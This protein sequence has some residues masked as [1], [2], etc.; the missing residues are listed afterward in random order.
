MLVSIV[1]R[2]YNE[3]RYLPALLAAIAA[4]DLQGLRV[5]TILVDSGST[6]G[7]LQIAIRAGCRIVTIQKTEFSFGRSLNRGCEAAAGQTLVFISGHC[8]PRDRNWLTN[9]VGPIADRRVTLTYGRQI[10][11]PESKFSEHQ[12]FAKYFPATDRL[13]QVGFFCNNANAAIRRDAWAA[14]RFDEALTGLEDMHLAQRLVRAGHLVGYVASA[15]VFHY[16][17]ESWATVRRRYEREAIALRR[18]MPDVHITV[19]DFVRYVVSAVYH[20]ARAALA[21]RRLARSFAEIVAFRAMQFW[22]AYRGNHEHRQLSQRKK[23]EYFYP[24]STLRD[25]A[26]AVLPVPHPDPF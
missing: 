12:L 3:S 6:D 10:G 5:E 9:L 13:P 26:P 1:I 4:Q 14:A 22:G 2:T 7:T 25:H 16:H 15:A 21:G 24:G 17:H 20:D 18:I 8:V 19:L 11:G 23:E